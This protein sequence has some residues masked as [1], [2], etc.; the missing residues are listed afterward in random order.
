MFSFFRRNKAK[1]SNNNNNESVNKVSLNMQLAIE[2]QQ[3]SL[4]ETLEQK[5]KNDVN[6]REDRDVSPHTA[7]SS[8]DVDDRDKNRPTTLSSFASECDKTN[9]LPNGTCAQKGQNY[10]QFRDAKRSSFFQYDSAQHASRQGNSPIHHYQ[11]IAEKFSPTA[12]VTSSIKDQKCSTSPGTNSTNAY[13]SVYEVMGRGRNRNK[14]RGGAVNVPQNYNK[15]VGKNQRNNDETVSKNVNESRKVTSENS[16][17]SLTNIELSP[18]PQ[19]LNKPASAVENSEKSASISNENVFHADDSCSI[20][21]ESENKND[22]IATTTDA[23]KKTA[24]NESADIVSAHDEKNENLVGSVEA[25]GVEN[26]EDS[27]QQVVGAAPLQRNPSAKRVTFAPSPPRSLAP[28]LSD[29][30]DDEEETLSED[31]VFYEAT[32]APSDTQKLRILSTVTSHSSDCSRIDEETSQ[33]DGST[34]NGASSLPSPSNFNVNNNNKDIVCGKIILSVNESEKTQLSDND[35]KA[36]NIK[37]NAFND[38]ETGSGS[39][40]NAPKT[41]KPS[42]ML[43]GEDN[44]ALPDIIAETSLLEQQQHHTVDEM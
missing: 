16:N 36:A 17:E 40:E 13:N 25:S 32:E 43:V 21:S 30:D 8:N 3:A 14:N 38:G 33:V 42:Y 29:D 37:N 39:V 19:I 44:I 7:K 18:E 23:E 24:A 31:L 6:D 9:I 12:V 10:D 11:P 35:E 22:N 5:R 41:I 1:P 20:N 4:H 34:S 27:Q 28:S 2:R 15:N 26:D